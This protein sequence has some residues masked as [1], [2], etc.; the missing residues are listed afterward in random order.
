MCVCVCVC[1]CACVHVCV[2]E[3]ERAKDARYSS[4]KGGRLALESKIHARKLTHARTRTHT[5]TRARAHTHTHAQTDCEI[6]QLRRWV[7][8][9]LAARSPSSDLNPKP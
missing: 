8:V 4:C 5:N 9:V 7:L 6:C 2:K 1:V 3:R